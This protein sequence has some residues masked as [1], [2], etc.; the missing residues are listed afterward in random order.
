M[1]VGLLTARSA[2]LGAKNDW[3]I[4]AGWPLTDVVIV[5]DTRISRKHLFSMGS[6]PTSNVWTVWA[7]W[8]VM[9]RGKP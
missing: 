5:L 3:K 6:T 7:E 9:E 8:E 1:T 2:R 4:F